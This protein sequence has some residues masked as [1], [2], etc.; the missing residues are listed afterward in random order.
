[1]F[2][3]DDTPGKQKLLVSAA[4]EL[5]GMDSRIGDAITWKLCA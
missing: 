1:V 5:P 2:G 4:S 3:D